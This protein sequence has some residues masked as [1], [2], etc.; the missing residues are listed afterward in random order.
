MKK[1]DFIGARLH[2]RAHKHARQQIM[3]WIWEQRAQGDVAGARINRHI[4]E[5]QL[6]RFGVLAAVR[7]QQ[8]DLGLAAGFFQAAAFDFALQAQHVFAGLGDV[9]IDRVELLHGG[10]RGGLVGGHQRAWCHR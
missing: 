1:R 6:A 5:L 9:D 2:H 7:Q 3:L 4:G 10:Q 8:G